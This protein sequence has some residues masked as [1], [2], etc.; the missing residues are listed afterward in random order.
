MTTRGLVGARLVVGDLVELNRLMLEVAANPG[1]R[2]HRVLEL[3]D[4]RLV[5]EVVEGEPDAFAAA[6]LMCLGIVITH[7]FADGNHRTSFTAGQL[8]LMTR[9]WLFLDTDENILRF[10]KWRFRHEDRRALIPQWMA[11]LGSWD[12]PERSRAFIRSFLDDA[13]GVEIRNYYQRRSVETPTD[14]AIAR[15]LYHNELR[16]YGN[17]TASKKRRFRRRGKRFSLL[18]LLPLL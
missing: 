15:T 16:R 12:S 7:P 6:T 18:D 4:L 13:Y 10:Y 17:R 8:V 3:A 9:G 1:D 5:L 2:P 14:E 11:S